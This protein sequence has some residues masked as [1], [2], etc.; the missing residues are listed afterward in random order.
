MALKRLNLRGMAKALEE[1]GKAFLLL[2]V[3][4]VGILM[5][6]SSIEKQFIVP[7]WSLI[8][9]LL[10]FIIGFILIYISERIRLKI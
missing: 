9:V 6:Q 2:G 10:S 4:M 8:T 7:I 5:F 1:T 3:L